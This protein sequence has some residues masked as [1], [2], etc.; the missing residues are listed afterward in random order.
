MTGYN[1]PIG[2]NKKI[3]LCYVLMMLGT[4]VWQMADWYYGNEDPLWHLA[5]YV[6]AMPFLS[7]VLGVLTGDDR[8]A[9]FIPFGSAVLSALI[10]IFMGNGG[11][12]VD[13]GAL[14]LCVPSF[15]AATIGVLVCRVIM[16]WNRN[17][18]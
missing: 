2:D 7:F 11:F 6:F 12:S 10:Y 18:E 15:I 8:R 3:I 14:Q 16:W 17:K 4:G 9:L 13:A 5:F 1:E